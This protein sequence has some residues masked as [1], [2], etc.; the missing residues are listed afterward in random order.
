MNSACMSF[1][2][3]MDFLST[4][5]T[6]EELLLDR[7]AS[8]SAVLVSPSSRPP[9]SRNWTQI[10]LYRSASRSASLQQETSSRIRT[11]R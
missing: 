11:Q 6:F 2:T 4:S 3:L 8:V 7:P 5:R 1:K 10:F 9:E